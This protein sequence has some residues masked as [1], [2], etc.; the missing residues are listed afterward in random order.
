MWGLC[1][2]QTCVKC[3]KNAGYIVDEEEGGGHNGAKALLV[4]IF[5]LVCFNVNQNCYFSP[6]LVVTIPHNNFELITFLLFH[7]PRICLKIIIFTSSFV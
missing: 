5:T 1:Y 2:K 3:C 6:K 4:T 7:I